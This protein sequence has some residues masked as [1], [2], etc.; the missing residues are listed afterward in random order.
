MQ[1]L[2]QNKHSFSFF[3][4]FKHISRQYNNK[5][6]KKKS[7]CNYK[8]KKFCACSLAEGIN[9]RFVLFIEFVHIAFI[10]QNKINLLSKYKVFETIILLI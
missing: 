7:T 3:K 10:F 1:F 9:I 5:N 2:Q 6:R 4:Q 8:N